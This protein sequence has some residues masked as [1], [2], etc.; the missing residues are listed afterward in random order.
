LRADRFTTGMAEEFV[1]HLRT[2]Q[3]APNGHP[4]ASRRALRD[5][6]PRSGGGGA[7]S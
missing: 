2:I 5:K 4:N 3:V 7:M 6:R 1:L